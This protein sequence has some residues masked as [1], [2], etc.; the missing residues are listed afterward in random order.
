MANSLEAGDLRLD[1][2]IAGDLAEV[3]AIFCDPH[4]HTIGDGPVTD[5]A[6]TARWLQGREDRLVEHGV[7]WYA[8]HDATGRMIGTAGLFMG[9]TDP[10]PEIGFEITHAEQNRGHGRAA[11]AAVVGEAH[12]AGFDEVWAS[13]RQRNA[14]S[15]RALASIG[16]VHVRTQ[17]DG[18]GDLVYLRHRSP[19]A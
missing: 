13:V 6:Q 19:A 3:H 5:I 15:L 2:L 11:A 9:R 8:V 7:T 14:A 1:V 17:S 16:F 12:R 10:F 4:T 18:R